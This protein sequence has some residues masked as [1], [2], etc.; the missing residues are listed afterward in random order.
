[1]PRKFNPRTYHSPAGVAQRAAELARFHATLSWY[2][3][4]R[5]HPMKGEYVLVRMTDG[6]VEGGTWK[7]ELHWGYSF[8]TWGTPD[9]FAFLARHHSTTQ[10]DGRNQVDYSMSGFASTSRRGDGE[11]TLVDLL[12][13]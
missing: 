10:W 9:S 11:R 4:D 6:R 8:C 12:S 2:Q 3:L 5:L 1:M 7:H 13:P